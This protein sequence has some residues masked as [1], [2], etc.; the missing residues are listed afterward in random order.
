MI[1]YNKSSAAGHEGPL[2][3]NCSV[4]MFYMMAVLFITLTINKF[5][6]RKSLGLTQ[7][8]MYSVL[9]LLAFLSE[10]HLIHPFSTDY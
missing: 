5:Q 9:L 3:A 4:L 10:F 2:G 1:K 7:M 8:V 6:A